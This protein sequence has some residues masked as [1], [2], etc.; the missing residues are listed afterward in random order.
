MP[1]DT[2]VVRGTVTNAKSGEVVAGALISVANDTLQALTD[3]AGRFVLD[4]VRTGYRTLIVQAFGYKGFVS[5]SFLVTAN[6]PAQVDM[7]LDP[8]LVEIGEVVVMSMP[9]VATVESP[10]SM[11]RIGTEEIDLTPGANRDISKVVQS[12]P[13]VVTVRAANR[14]D[15]LVRGGGANENRYYLD[16]IEIPVLNHFSVQGGSGGNASLVNTEQL[17]SVDFYTS[18]FPVAISTGLSSVLDMQMRSGNSERFHG[19]VVAG[20]SDLG[21]SFDTPVSR[22]G[23]TTLI[24]SFRRSYLKLLFSL[25]KLPFLP[26]YNDYQ[27]KLNSV[28]SERD[29]LYVIGLGSFDHN[30]LN[31]GS[32]ELEP[33]RRYILGYLPENNQLSYAFGVGYLRSFA[34]GRLRVVLSRD[35]LR[36]QL[37]KH[38]RNDNSLPRIMD[39]DSR[40]TNH[41]LRVET[42]W[43]NVGR[44]RITAGIGGGSGAYSGRT[45]QRLQEEGVWRES[46]SRSSFTVWRYAAFGTVSRYFFG[47]RLSALVGL[48]IDG[49]TYSRLM[50]NPFRH[51][52]PRLSLSWKVAPKWSLNASAGRYY[53]EP[54]FTMMG[55]AEN[56]PEGFDQ[57]NGLRYMSVDQYVVGV[58]FS[59]T[60]ISDLRLEAFFKGYRRLPVSLVDSLPVS[61]GD[62]A[63]FIVG[64]VPVL[65]VGKGRAYGVELSY[66]NLDLWN[67][68]VGLSYTLFWSKVNKLDDHLVPVSE[69]WSSSWDARHI[70][71]ISAIHKFARNWSLGLKWNLTGGLPFTPY[72]EELS[73]LITAWDLRRRPYPDYALYNACRSEFYHQLDVRVDKVWY[74]RKW[75]LGFYVDIQNLYNFKTRG[76]DILMPAVD[77]A[78]DYIVDETRPG[79]Y[80]MERIADDIGGTILPTIG[81]TIEL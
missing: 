25:L 55:Y 24:G 63:D 47:E 3:S 36:N 48:R 40:E 7:A 19:K 60:T 32:G 2:G 22:N 73:S 50:S 21:V 11:R 46:D 29:V 42:E 49:M 6:V 51:F 15:L 1:P 35:Y 53:Q 33:S 72:D 28:L 10:V 70:L 78:G 44:F 38:E 64:N 43:W 57:R 27:F 37:Y 69:Y 58:N 17:R 62:F 80:K 39:L 41:R 76:S 67:T 52:S 30:R 81:I 77:A 75:R 4:R 74:F 12:A 14:N 34:S 65:S 45:Q 8:Q 61:T 66:R 13:G 18:A 16:G 20:A 56:D 9:F 71:N 5:S 26:T 79:H 68:V 59:P 54:T 31:T 23:R